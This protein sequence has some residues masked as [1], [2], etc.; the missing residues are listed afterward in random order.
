MSEKKPK[1]FFRYKLGSSDPIPKNHKHGD[2][3]H[4]IRPN[5]DS[6][7]FVDKKNEYHEIENK[8][9]EMP[10]V[11]SVEV[12]QC[13]RF[14]LSNGISFITDSNESEFYKKLS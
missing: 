4:I 2:I 8:T 5:G 11:E 1:E 14:T 9:L 12:I 6:L 10:M 7:Y 3:V 13:L